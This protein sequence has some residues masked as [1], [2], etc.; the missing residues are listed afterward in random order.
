MKENDYTNQITKLLFNA[1]SG[2]DH[3]EN[4]LGPLTPEPIQEAYQTQ[5][6]LNSL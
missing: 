3:H 6:I 4:L 1:H 2:R 5:Q